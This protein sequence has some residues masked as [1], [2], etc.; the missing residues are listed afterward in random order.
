MRPTS[1][2]SVPP[3]AHLEPAGET[4]RRRSVSYEATRQIKRG[5]AA[6]SSRNAFFF[7]NNAASLLHKRYSA[8]KK[9]NGLDLSWGAE[10]VRSGIYLAHILQSPVPFSAP[11]GGYRKINRLE[12][13]L[14]SPDIE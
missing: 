14:V 9:K 13:K 4:T 6:L 5:R 8:K 2:P 11:A 3:P 7:G 12:K 10:T 1:P